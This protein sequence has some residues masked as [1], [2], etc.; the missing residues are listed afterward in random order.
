MG[1]NCRQETD[2]ELSRP[3]NCAINRPN[4]QEIE[5]GI[6]ILLFLWDFGIKLLHLGTFLCSFI[7]VNQY[8]LLPL[9]SFLVS[10]TSFRTDSTRIFHRTRVGAHIPC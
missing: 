10:D 4:V 8:V 7:I 1:S 5:L 6:T 2:T 9:N 3:P